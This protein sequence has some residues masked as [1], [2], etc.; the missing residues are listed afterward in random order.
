MLL[1]VLLW[2][3]AWFHH[4]LLFGVVAPLV[5]AYYLTT[6]HDQTPPKPTRPRRRQSNSNTTDDNLEDENANVAE[7]TKELAELSELLPITIMTSKSFNFDRKSNIVVCTG[8]TLFWQYIIHSARLGQLA[9]FTGCVF[10]TWWSPWVHTVRQVI[11]QQRERRRQ[12]QKKLA[13]ISVTD[14]KRSELDRMYCFSVYEHQRWWLHCGWTNLMLPHDRPEWSDE[15]LEPTPSID[16]FH[17]PP[18]S[19]SSHWTWVDP[20]WKPDL[21][22]VKDDDGWEYGNWDW[23]AWSDK[24]SGLSVLTRRRRWIRCARLE[25]TILQNAYAL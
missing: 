21:S 17:L 5:L 10:L 1:I 24:R 15:Y 7:I 14:M 19:N 11:C 2:T 12:Q 3:A 23:K 8:L 25:C 6:M 20:S 4:K 22:G 13:S 9:W 16:A 18:P